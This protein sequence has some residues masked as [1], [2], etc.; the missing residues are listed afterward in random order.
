MLQQ[1][2]V[3]VQNFLTLCG[4]VFGK[5]GR[6]NHLMMIHAVRRHPAEYF[7][8]YNKPV[9]FEVSEIVPGTVVGEAGKNI[10]SSRRAA[11]LYTGNDAIYRIP[12]SH[13]SCSPLSYWISV[14]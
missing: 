4:W 1:Q 2:N 11:L 3:L 5:H 10:I 7:I 12:I 6:D 9:A 8:K 13:R 14:Q